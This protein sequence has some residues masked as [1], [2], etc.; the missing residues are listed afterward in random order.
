MSSSYN[1]QREVF[2][3]DVWMDGGREASSVYTLK[4]KRLEVESSRVSLTFTRN[5]EERAEDLGL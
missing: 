4:G 3:A 5:L 2:L 1:R